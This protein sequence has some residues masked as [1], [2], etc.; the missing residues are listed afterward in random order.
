MYQVAP[1]LRA[2]YTIQTGVT[3]ERQIT[4]V[5]TASLTYLNSRGNHVLDIRNVN[6][7]ADGIYPNGQAESVYQYESEGIFKQNQLIANTTIRMGAKLSLFGFYTYGHA[8]SDTSGTSTFPYNE[9]TLSKNYGRASFDV[10]NRVFL[11]G[12]IGMPYNLRLNPFL[13]A[14]SGMPFNITTSTD[15]NGDSIIGNDRPYFSG[16]TGVYSCNGTPVAADFTKIANAFPVPV[17][18]GTGSPQFSLNLRLSKTFGFGKQSGTSA[19]AAPPGGGGGGPHGG[20]GPGMVGM[21]GGGPMNMGGI[22]NQRYNVTFSLS[23]RNLLN[24]VSPAAPIGNI[25]AP[26]DVF[27]KPNSLAGGPGGGPFG[28]SSSNRRID[29][30]IT[31]N[32]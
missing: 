8:N 27:E 25:D 6:T 7:P 18:C 17:N 29:M 30:Q 23:A 3:I 22:T 24:F 5:A 15:I 20:R 11:G 12:S 10:R 9:T 16:A 28:S 4:K 14:S 13:I 1:N 2:P 21:A 26:S 19:A 31:F 32:F